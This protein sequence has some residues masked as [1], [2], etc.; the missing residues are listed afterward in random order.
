MVGAVQIVRMAGT[1]RM[2]GA[3]LL[4]GVEEVE[5]ETVGSARAAVTGYQ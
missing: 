1:L 4:A 2:A 3:V 5:E